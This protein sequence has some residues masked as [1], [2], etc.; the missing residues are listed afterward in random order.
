MDLIIN[1]NKEYLIPSS[2]SINIIVKKNITATLI[3]K[4]NDN[5]D[6]K[7]SLEPNSNI[8]YLS[9]DLA[10]NSNKEITMSKDSNLNM[11]ISNFNGGNKYLKVNLDDENANL[12]IKSIIMMKN[13]LDKETIEV[14]HNAKNTSSK[15]ENYITSNNA[16][17]NIDVIGKIKKDMSNSNCV[18]KSRGIILSN[19]STIKVMPVLLIDEFD[20]S[21]N[22][23]CAI[24]KID[25]EGLYYLMS[26]GISKK[27]AE[28]LIIKGFLSPILNSLSNESMKDELIK[29]QDSKL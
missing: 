28:M 2:E 19:N 20:V 27:D 23:G 14:Y 13:D 16:K 25:E 12:D 18:Q 5:R 17:V 9:I 21:A 22:H 8:N 29:L 7:I 6:I 4:N 24:G 3:E 26:R 10:N 1:E 15:I 11:V